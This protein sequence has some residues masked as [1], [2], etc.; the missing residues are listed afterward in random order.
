MSEV[1]FNSYLAGFIDGEGG[2]HISKRREKTRENYTP[3]LTITNQN[4][5][6]LKAIKQRLGVGHMCKG[7]SGSSGRNCFRYVVEC[8]K[9]KDVLR[10]VIHQLQIKREQA[11]LLYVFPIQHNGGSIS[12]PTKYE[13]VN[14]RIRKIQGKIWMMMRELN[15]SRNQIL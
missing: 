4:L 1:E 14:N 12:F 15:A 8:S 11:I 9:T 5:D 3:T 10:R 2:I 7:K 13:N 6:V